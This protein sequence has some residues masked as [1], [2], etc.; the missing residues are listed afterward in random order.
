MNHC[1]SCHYSSERPICRE[2][3]SS[4]KKKGKENSFEEYTDCYSV[5]IIRNGAIGDN[6]KHGHEYGEGP[7][8][9]RATVVSALPNLMVLDGTLVSPADRKHYRSWTK[10]ILHRGNGGESLE[11]EERGL[12]EVSCDKSCSLSIIPHGEDEMEVA[13]SVLG[14]D[15]AIYACNACKLIIMGPR[16]QCNVVHDYHACSGCFALWTLSKRAKGLEKRAETQ[17]DDGKKGLGIMKEISATAAKA[18][19]VHD[20]YV[21]SSVEE[22]LANDLE[23]VVVAPSGAI[24]LDGTQKRRSE[25]MERARRRREELHDRHQSM[26]RMIDKVKAG[27]GNDGCNIRLEP[28][29]GTGGVSSR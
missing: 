15:G 9:Y 8:R 23:K 18:R 22:E 24:E 21:T 19:L 2:T 17:N 28:A 4:G 10:S 3:I 29:C 20:F 1:L 6:E 16:F 27:E 13:M 5:G 7:L 14:T 12:H 26:L 11:K 25:F